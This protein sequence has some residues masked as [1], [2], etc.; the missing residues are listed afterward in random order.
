MK[1]LISLCLSLVLALALAVPASA[2]ETDGVTMMVNGEYIDFDGGAPEISGGRTMAPMRGVLEALGAEV[3][4]DHASKTVTASM[5][6]VKLTHTIGTTEITLSGGQ[7]LT[8]DAASYVKNGSVMVPLRFFSQAFGYEVYW[9]RGQRTA[10]VI[11]KQGL[12]DQIDASFTIV[13]DLQ[14][15]QSAGRSENLAM[16]LDFSGSAKLLDAIEGVK[17]Y[18]FSLEMTGLYGPSAINAEGTIDLSTLPAAM[19]A[20]GEEAPEEMAELLEDLDFQMIYSDAGM[21]MQLPTLA[22]LLLGAVPGESDGDVW[23]QL[24]SAGAGDI[25]DL[26]SLTWAAG[27]ESATMGGMLYAMAEFADTDVPVNIYGDVAE[28]AELLTALVGDD[29]FTKDGGDYTWEMDQAMLDKLAEALGESDMKLPGTVEM[30][31]KAD[32]SSEFSMELT[33]DEEP[34]A[35]VVS[36]SGTSTATDSAFQGRILVKNICNVTFQGTAKVQSSDEAPLPAP[37][38]DAEIVSLDEAA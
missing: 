21:W 20:M 25:L 3:D 13:N 8:M 31:L 37:P 11:D 15:K 5:G 35:L 6:D 24:D 10:V 1:K 9:D 12:I 18:P 30:T 4:Y 26:Y 27:G 22:P 23:F 17:E 34:L 7:V 2:A 16:E 29:T 19:A 32:G 36:L 14:A 33:V 28:A 38:A